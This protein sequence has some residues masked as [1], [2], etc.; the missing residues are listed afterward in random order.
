M[1]TQ[2]V[3][4]LAT[5]EQCPCSPRGGTDWDPWGADKGGRR[6]VLGQEGSTNNHAD[7]QVIERCQQRAPS[8]TISWS[9]R[10]GV[11]ESI[12]HCKRSHHCRGTS[13]HTSAQGKSTATRLRKERGGHRQREDFGCSV[14]PHHFE[15]FW[16]GYKQDEELRVAAVITPQS[17]QGAQGLPL[18]CPKPHEDS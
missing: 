18:V 3:T 15:L 17:N 12:S 14:F 1:R 8:S 6:A 11:V 5:H 7:A 9:S 16:V 4:E 13:M 10:F 2:V